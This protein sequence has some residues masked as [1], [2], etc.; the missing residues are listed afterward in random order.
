MEFVTEFRKRLLRALSLRAMSQIQ[1][2]KDIGVAAST[3]NTWCKGVATPSVYY[4]P[5][6]CKS[7]N[8]SADYLVGL[9]DEVD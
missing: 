1:L 6:I 2:A 9:K 5:W 8:V 7:L 4:L 3:V